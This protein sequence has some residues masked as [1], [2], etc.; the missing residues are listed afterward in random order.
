MTPLILVGV[1]KVLV[2]ETK[3]TFAG[4]VSVN[5]TSEAMFGPRFVML[6]VKVRLLPIPVERAELVVTTLKS[7]R[8]SL[9][10]QTGGATV[11]SVNRQPPDTLPE[12]PTE[13]SFT[14]KLQVPVGSVPLKTDRLAP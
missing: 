13:S 14:Y 1:P 9:P 2:T 6:I 8:L 4:K 5:T 3:L 10:Q 11:V 7:A 12:S